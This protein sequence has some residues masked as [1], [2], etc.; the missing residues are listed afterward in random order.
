MWCVSVAAGSSEEQVQPVLFVLNIHAAL[1]ALQ[2]EL[3]TLI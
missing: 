2:A 3:C 1:K